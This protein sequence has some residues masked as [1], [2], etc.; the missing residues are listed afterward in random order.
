MS[1]ETVTI[2]PCTLIRGDC[3]EVL[4]TLRGVDAVVTDPPY[5]VNFKYGSHDDTRDGYEDWCCRWFDECSRVSGG[6]ILMSCGAVNVPMWGRVR[7]FRWQIA[8]L[9]PAA[10]GRS[11]VGFCNWEPMPMWGRGSGD[12][13]DVFTAAIVPDAD[14]DWHPCPKP[15]QWGRKAIKVVPG[16]SVLDPFLGS[17][18]TAVACLMAGREFIGIE[19]DSEYFRRACERIRKAWKLERSKLPLERQP[20]MKQQELIST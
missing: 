5:G 20:L 15:L 4:P 13:V 12:A 8:W 10:M 18:T 17:G 6:N 11:P 9:K 2:G 19:K 7:P 14:V 3:L 16:E 1:F